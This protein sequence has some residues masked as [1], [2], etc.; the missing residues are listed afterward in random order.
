[1]LGQ[2]L[3]PRNPAVNKKDTVYCTPVVYNLAETKIFIMKLQVSIQKEDGSWGYRHTKP[4]L[5]G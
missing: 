4:S 5:S 1:M 3:G 2:V